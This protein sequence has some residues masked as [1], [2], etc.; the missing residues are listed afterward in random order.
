[1]CTTEVD[2]IIRP[3]FRWAISPILL[4][5]ETWRQNRSYFFFFILADKWASTPKKYDSVTGTT[6]P[7]TFPRSSK[8]SRILVCWFMKP[9]MLHLA[10]MQ[11]IVMH[12]TSYWRFGLWRRILINFFSS[13]RAK[14]RGNM[15]VECTK[16]VSH[17]SCSMRVVESVIYWFVYLKLPC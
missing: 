16:C 9:S 12:P 8:T 1:M 6:D 17:N 10:K 14:P 2:V 5:V 3:V 15:T 13:R 4:V 7:V 11:G